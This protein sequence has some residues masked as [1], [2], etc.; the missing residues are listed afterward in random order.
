LITHI[1]LS[2]QFSLLLLKNF[3]YV[4]ILLL[5]SLE[6]ALEIIILEAIELV[7]KLGLFLPR[8]L[9]LSLQVPNLRACLL[10]FKA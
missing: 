4:L 8:R 3:E 10:E 9:C 7:L 1:N 2:P 5:V 6:T